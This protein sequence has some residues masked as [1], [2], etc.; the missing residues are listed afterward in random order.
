MKSEIER[1]E[2]LEKRVAELSQKIVNFD[3]IINIFKQF[4]EVFDRLSDS[5]DY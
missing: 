1:I 3:K 4:K 5:V 2:Y